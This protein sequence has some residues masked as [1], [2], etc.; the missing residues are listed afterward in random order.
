[1]LGENLKTVMLT[2]EIFIKANK[3]FDLEE[4]YE[5]TEYMIKSRDQNVFQNQNTVIGNLSFEK[6]WKSS[7]IW[8]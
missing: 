3:D 7:N 4:N 1:M 2:T 5:K 8:I 6:T